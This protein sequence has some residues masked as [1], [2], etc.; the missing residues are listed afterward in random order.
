MPCHLN[1]LG[2]HWQIG[3]SRGDHCDRALPLGGHLGGSVPKESSDR[4]V[5]SATDF[6]EY[7]LAHFGI[8]PRDEHVLFGR[9]QRVH[10]RDD[11]LGCLAGRVDD[12]GNAV[13]KR[14]VGVDARIRQI[15]E[16]QI[17]KS[18]EGIR[19]RE[20]STP[21]RFEE[22]SDLFSIQRQLPARASKFCAGHAARY[23]TQSRRGQQPSI[24]ERT[25]QNRAR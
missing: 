10:N 9:A 1:C 6:C 19:R 20:F 25:R 17:G 21:Y 16:G 22:I 24:E 13:A 2:G 23:Q 7:A 3:S 8:D 12:F 14:A 15:R 11:L 4:V 5:S 18:L